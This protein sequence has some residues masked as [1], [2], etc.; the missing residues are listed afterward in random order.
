MFYN[1]GYVPKLKD[2]ILTFTQQNHT[3]MLSPL[4]RL[5]ANPISPC[6]RLSQKHQLFISP[7]K[8]PSFPPSP[9]RPMSYILLR[10]PAKDLRAINQM[11]QRNTGEK[12]PM[13]K[14]ILQDD[15]NESEN[16]PAKRAHTDPV[17]IRS[18]MIENICADRQGT[19]SEDSSSNF[20]ENG[21]LDSNAD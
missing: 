11:M 10:S 7:M 9:K 12:K 6:R 13:I 1:Q 17:L 14:R 2:Y 8:A 21:S 20:V 16:S 5:A 15:M 4:P 19:T 18:K 3:Q